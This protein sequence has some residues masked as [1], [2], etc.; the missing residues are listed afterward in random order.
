[1]FFCVRNVKCN[2]EKKYIRAFEGQF[3][4]K[5]APYEAD[6]GLPRDRANFWA[7]GQEYEETVSSF[8]L[9]SAVAIILRVDSRF[10]QQQ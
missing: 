10:R 9:S 7:A 5:W 6:L 8:F 2:G 3:C 1:M 4:L